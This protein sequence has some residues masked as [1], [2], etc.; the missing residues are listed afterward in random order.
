MTNGPSGAGL[1]SS[2]LEPMC[3]QTTVSVSVHAAQTGSQYSLMSDG[4]PSETG[5]SGKESARGAL[6]CVAPDLVRHQGRVPDLAHDEGHV[7]LGRRRAPFVEMK[8]VVGAH[9]EVG[10]RLVVVPVEHPPPEPGEGG[11]AQAGPDAVVGHVLGPL[12]RV[13]AAWDHVAEARRLH[14]PFFLRLA[15]HRVEP[16]LRRLD[17]LPHPVL[18]AVLFD[19]VRADVVVL[20]GQAVRPHRGVLDDV[21]V[22][23]EQVVGHRSPSFD[24]LT[25]IGA[26]E[27]NVERPPRGQVRGVSPVAL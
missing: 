10:E 12:G 14:R 27:G 4:N 13:V 20:G 23:T 7:E 22:D 16:H 25:N 1:V 8:V 6:G 11:K 19:D 24:L 9:A 3:M 5:P 26:P 15:G 17:S 21:V 2:P 18:A